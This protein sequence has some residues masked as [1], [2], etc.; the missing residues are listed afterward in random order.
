MKIIQK[1]VYQLI[2]SLGLLLVAVYFAE[3]K[4]MALPHFQVQSPKTA[5][6]QEISIFDADNGHFYVFLPSYAEMEQ[7]TI[8]LPNNRCFSLGDSVLSDGMDCSEFEL[9][10]PYSFAV[11][12]QQVAT[13][14]FHQSANIATMYIDT[15]TGSMDR[16]HKDKDYKEQASVVL[17]TTDGEINYSDENSALKGRGNSTWK[18]E[19]RPYALTL[20]SSEKLLDMG[21]ATDWCL[22]AN[23]LDHSNLNNKIVYHLANRVGFLW[24]PKCEYVDVYLNGEYNGLYL[25]SEKVETGV[26]RLSIDLGSGDFLCTFDFASRISDMRNHLHT[27]IGRTV[28]ICEPE[29]ITQEEKQRIED[30]VNQQEQDILSGHI[31]S[32]GSIVD[33]DSWIRRYLIDELA[34]NTDADLS[35]SYFYYTDGMFYAGPV[36]DYDIAFGNTIQNANP[37]A[38]TAKNR[39]KYGNIIEPYYSVLFTNPAFYDRMAEIYQKEFVPVL[40]ELIEHDIQ[41]IADTIHSAATANSI[42]WPVISASQFDFSTWVSYSTSGDSIT[43]YLRQKVAFLNDALINRVAYATLQFQLPDGGAYWSVSVPVGAVLETTDVINE[44]FYAEIAKGI[45]INSDTEEVVDLS[46][47]IT[48]DMILVRPAESTD[49]YVSLISEDNITKLSIAML[50]VMLM[51][52]ITI[53][54]VQR[55]KERGGTNG[56]K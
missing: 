19:K 17:Y 39:V 1:Y 5:E 46:R 37:Q 35:S 29:I 11:N 8:S 4:V 43:Q 33:I 38:F 18:R 56:R 53:D 28:E 32:A 30:L 10:K 50:L 27:E 51:A 47:P 15:V 54:V 49:S 45:W 14:S 7:V 16:I 21:A 36:W 3:G 34:G 31:G 48:M 44:P 55:G 9:E 42:R 24:T 41:D 2:I 26:D 40:N 22:L 52:F 13:L 23:F 6:T 12:K 25:L 20:A